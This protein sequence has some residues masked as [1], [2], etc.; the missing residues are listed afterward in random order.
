[1]LK[2]EDTVL[3]IIDIQGKLASLMQDKEIIYENVRRCIKAAEVL[4]LPILWLEQNPAHLGT[5][6]SEIAELFPDK[7]PITKM[8]FSAYQNETFKRALTDTTRRQVLLVGIETHIC[9]YNTARD[10]LK[11][12]Y[13]IYVV[14]DAVS[15]RTKENKT[16]GLQAMLNSGVKITSTEMALYELLGTAE[17]P[18]FKKIL[19]IVK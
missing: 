8:H 7:K 12:G 19:K 6:I 9:I 15:S 10:L 16:I 18:H 5:T 17:N 13:D 11:A 2:I 4:S 3:V 1:M 14:A